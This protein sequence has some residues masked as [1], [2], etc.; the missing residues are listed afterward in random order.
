MGLV[1]QRGSEGS[2]WGAYT[3]ADPILQE[4]SAPPRLR[5]ERVCPKGSWKHLAMEVLVLL[6][7][8]A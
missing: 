7:K 3:C 1:E 4:G 5:R 6:L 2:P 8:S